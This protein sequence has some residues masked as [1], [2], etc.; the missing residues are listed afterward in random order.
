MRSRRS[1]V[2]GI[3]ALLA[4]AGRAGCQESDSGDALAQIRAKG[5][6]EVAVYAQFPPFSSGR[7]TQDAQGI[8]VDI[9]QAIAQQLG[10]RLRLRLIAAGEST[11]DDLRNHI[12]KGHYMGGGA[13]DVMLHVGYDPVF[14]DR[15]KSVILCAPYFHEAVVVAYQPSR[16]PHLESP[17]ASSEHRIGVEGDTISDHIVSSAYGGS[18]RQAVVRE[19]SLEEAAQALK[20]GQVDAVMGPKG[21]LQGLLSGLGMTGVSFHPQERVGQ[22]RTSWDIGLAVKRDGGAG[23]SEAVGKAVAALQADGSLQQIFK[24]YGV[25]YVDA[26]TRIGGGS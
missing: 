16:I 17:V 15:E 8:D 12:W 18:L 22:M 1:L 13:A 10:V 21:Q 24:H 23:L 25:D 3:G 11:S 5:A 19:A 14:A 20:A 7:S 4:V 6:I 2:L 9:A 26:Q